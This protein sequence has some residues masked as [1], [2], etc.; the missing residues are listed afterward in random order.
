MSQI[1]VRLFSRELLSN[2]E[3]QQALVRLA[4]WLFS[5][6]F[7]WLAATTDYYAVDFTLFIVLYQCYLF[8]FLTILGSIIYK[9]YLPYR[10][11]VVLFLD[12]SA[13]SLAIV[14]TSDA[15][16]PFY[17][18]Y[19]WIY[20]SYGTRYGK[21]LLMLAAPLTLLAYSGVLLYLDTWTSHG[22]DAFFFQLLL[23]VLPLYQYF[24]L[25]QLHVAKEE[26]ER[27]K[28]ARGDFLVTMTHELRSPLIGMIGMTRLMQG[29]PLDREQKEYLH[30]IQSSAHMLRSLISDVVDLSKIDANKLELAVEWLDIRKLVN[31]VCASLAEEAHDKQLELLCWV[32]PQLPQEI[33]G[34]KLRISQILFNLLGNAVKF[35]EKGHV[36]LELIYADES[37]E[38]T[39]AH[40]L[41]KVEDSG[42]GIPQHR[43]ASVFDCFWHADLGNGHRFEGAGLGITVVRDLTRLMGGSVDL[44]SEPGVGSTFFARLP[45]RMRGGAA[46]SKADLP[47]AGLSLLI[48]EQDPVAMRHHCK[49]ANEFGMQVI[50]A[51]FPSE[52][53]SSLDS[54]VDLLLVCDSQQDTTIKEILYKAQAVTPSLPIIVA[55]YRGRLNEMGIVRDPENTLTKPFLAEDLAFMVMNALGL[56]VNLQQAPIMGDDPFAKSEGIKILLAEDNAIAAKVLSTLLIQRGHNVYITRD[57]GEALQAVADN[58]FELAFIDLQMPDIDGLEFARRYRSSEPEYR[59]MP[60]F[61]MTVNS[62][63]EMLEHCVEA[64]MDGFLPKPVEPEKLDAILDQYRSGLDRNA[65]SQPFPIPT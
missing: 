24:L 16:S 33:Y 8:L 60:I 15:I 13:T 52:F 44:V 1:F 42:V 4:I 17:L 31:S 65:F 53:L 63:E 9:P 12:V 61:A 21:R 37:R 10:T 20:I 55:G 43:Q 11:V 39:Q 46:I 27:A 41:I 57:G 25:R 32:D 47:L 14:I 19:L 28:K 18:I 22:F 62:I 56:Q 2:S 6:I 51:N 38:L 3:Y 59:Y 5:I 45:L 48:Y 23:V 29:T 40:L 64:G 50:C 58:E 49:V 54:S 7:M 26:A 34:D 30:S 36:R 35:T